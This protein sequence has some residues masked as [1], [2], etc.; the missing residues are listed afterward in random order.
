MIIQ[1][2]S[3]RGTIHIIKDNLVGFQ[4]VKEVE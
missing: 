3:E 1:Q 2:H 4:E